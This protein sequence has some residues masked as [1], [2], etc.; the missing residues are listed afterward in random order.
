MK[1]G[2]D[3]DKQATDE[4]RPKTGQQDADKPKAPP[5]PGAN[6]TSTGLGQPTHEQQQPASSDPNRP[7]NLPPDDL[8]KNPFGGGEKK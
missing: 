8:M 4:Q 1:F 6:V 2:K 3:D 5:P 7:V